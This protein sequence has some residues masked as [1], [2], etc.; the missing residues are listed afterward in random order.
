MR[1]TR[2]L[3]AAALVLS[4]SMAWPQGYPVGPEFRVNTY[5]TGGQ[6]VQGVAADPSGKFLV[7]WWGQGVGETDGVFGQRYDSSGIPVGP[8]FHVN[9]YTTNAQARARVAADAS[10]KFVMVWNSRTQDGSD[11]GV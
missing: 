5:T 7:V 2:F 6:A 11:Y 8:E 4:P 10:G 3:C 9:T 1:P